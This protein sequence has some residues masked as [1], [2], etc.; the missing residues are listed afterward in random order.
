VRSDWTLVI[1]AYDHEA[2][3]QNALHQARELVDTDEAAVEGAAVVTRSAAGSVTV[4]GFEAGAGERGAGWG[5]L[6]GAAVGVLFPPSLLGTALVGAA[7]GGLIGRHRSRS[8]RA[9]AEAVANTLPPNCSGL[10]AVTPAAHADDLDG[11]LRDSRRVT[12]TEIGH[13][14]VDALRSATGSD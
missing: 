14:V 11:V 1:G 7:G 3:A 9:L 2:D 5:T 8:S 13:D 4:P 6:A 12:K 10:L